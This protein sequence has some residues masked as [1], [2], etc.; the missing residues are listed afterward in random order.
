[1]RSACWQGAHAT[2]PFSP[3]PMPGDGWLWGRPLPVPG[4][5]ARVT[6]PGKGE[7]AEPGGAIPARE[8]RH[9]PTAQ[10]FAS[11]VLHICLLSSSWL[12]EVEEP[13]K[14]L[15]RA[16]QPGSGRAMS[17]SQEEQDPNPC[18]EPPCHTASG[19]VPGRAEPACGLASLPASAQT[20][21]GF[22]FSPCWEGFSS[23]V[24]TRFLQLPLVPS[25]VR[26]PGLLLKR[27]PGPQTEH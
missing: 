3:L 9:S 17:Q 13:G 14:W 2:S 10:L 24:G 22:P 4:H 16:S 8:S 21:A 19:A 20:Q 5:P 6:T 18:P 25:P 15:A 1:M 11:F 23:R 7:Q 26:R 12:Y 27:C